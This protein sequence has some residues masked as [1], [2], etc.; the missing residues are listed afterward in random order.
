M[1][2]LIKR[3]GLGERPPYEVFTDNEIILNEEIDDSKM[4]K[5]VYEDIVVILSERMSEREN[6]PKFEVLGE[7]K[8]PTM[9]IMMCDAMTC[10]RGQWLNDV[11][12]GYFSQ[13]FMDTT[14]KIQNDNKFVYVMRSYF[15]TLLLGEGIREQ[16]NSVGSVT[17][18]PGYNFSRVESWWP[19]YAKN[20]S[21][22]T[23]NPM[24]MTKIIL[25]INAN[26]NHWVGVVIYPKLRILELLDS[27]RLEDSKD[28]EKKEQQ[29][30]NP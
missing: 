22:V 19:N 16:K 3:V 26:K 5:D 28:D 24:D 15:W 4:T 10:R 9:P 14:S 6:S 30:R 13:V 12:I 27:N 25:H 23:S 20:T 21:H 8:E 2:Y 11:V 18:V 7:V 29:R 1:K 17:D